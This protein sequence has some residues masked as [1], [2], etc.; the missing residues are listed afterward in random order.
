MSSLES[1]L[2]R[3]FQYDQFR[4]GQKQVIEAVLAG[5]DVLAMLPTGTGKSI[6]YQ[7]PALLL[8]G[9]AIIVSP[10]LSLMEDQ[11][12]QL[13][14]IG[15]KKAVA[16]N[17]FLSWEERIKVVNQ[18]HLYKLVYVSPEVLQ[19]SFVIQKLKTMQISLFVIDEAHCISQW[20]HEFR[21][22][23]LKLTQVRTMLQRPPC[24]AL[25]ATATKEI[26]TDIIHHLQLTNETR[27]LYSV[28]R[29]NIAIAVEKL[30]TINDKVSILTK[31]VSE[32][33]G[34]G[35]IYFSSRAWAEK[36]AMHLRDQGID[37]VAY[38][39]GGLSQED[40][41]LIQQQFMNEQLQII[42]CTNAFGMGI[43]KNNVRF[44]IHF[45][46]PNQIESYLQEIGRAGRDQQNSIAILLYCEEDQVLPL[47]LIDH[48][49]PTVEQLRIVLSFLSQ[50]ERLEKGDDLLL[51][52]TANLEETVWRFIQYH[53]E[54]Q[55]VL[56]DGVV[57]IKGR[58][59]E[60]VELFERK[61]K[62][63]VKHKAKKLSEIEEWIYSSSC[64]RTGYL[65]LF[66]QTL[67]NKPEQCCTECGIELD[68]Y[69]KTGENR[70]EKKIEIS[71][72]ELQLKQIFHQ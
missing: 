64:K 37:N 13:H 36:M 42:C 72:W 27:L 58:E 18:L 46:Y 2:K 1:A 55:N 11:V 71:N 23:Y 65:H 52:Q 4:E 35:M 54:E 12:Q 3:F 41:I 70:N 57:S 6:C 33:Q 51:Q 59:Q 34:P 40:R 63:R 38:Y 43:N 29:P 45:H 50:V 25:T 31:Y 67:I 16:L 30:E 19:S 60:M 22:D 28:D 8:E 56:V 20:G 44:V 24:L 21:T 5:D 14:S 47:S 32:L 49:F 39:H 69:R 66:D 9:T 62:E 17:S 26:Q 61:I 48:E 15:L 68:I 7:L 10:L 53:L